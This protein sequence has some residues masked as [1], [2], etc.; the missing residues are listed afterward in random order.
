MIKR[1]ITE[2]L[3]VL[4]MRNTVENNSLAVIIPT[5][6][7]KSDNLGDTGSQKNLQIVEDLK[8]I[9]KKILHRSFKLRI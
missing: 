9:T 8:Q 7:G 2:M 5:R 1:S 4:A 6:Q 3:L